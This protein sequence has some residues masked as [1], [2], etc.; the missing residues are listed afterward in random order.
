MTNIFACLGL[1]VPL[2]LL[3]LGLS[4]LSIIAASLT[5]A[6]LLAAASLKNDR[7][8]DKILSIYPRYALASEGFQKLQNMDMPIREKDPATG[9]DRVTTVGVLSIDEPPWRTLLD[10]IRSETAIRKSERNEPV[11]LQ[12]IMRPPPP[13]PSAD[14]GTPEASTPPSQPAA[15]SPTTGAQPAAPIVP[16]AFPINFERIKTIIS[17]RNDVA[18]AG[19]KPLSPPFALVVLWPG[20][21]AHRVYEFLSFEEFRLDLRRV[22]LGEIEE[23]ALWIS[24]LAFAFGLPIYVLRSLAAA[25]E[26][27][28]LARKLTN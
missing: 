21:V 2:P 10:F 7:L 22:I 6:G 5:G 20:M 26:Q 14:K 9:K 23:L 4:L 1:R 3:R 17:V 16:Q 15:A 24:V 11:N 18:T 8:A 27:R 19:T 25:A 28:E 13:S 12:P